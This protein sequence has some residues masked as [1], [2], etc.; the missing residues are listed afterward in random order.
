[1]VPQVGGQ[2]DVDALGPRSVE[3]EVTRA[4]AQ[5]ADSTSRSGSPATRTPWAVCGEH[6]ADLRGELPQRH[7]RCEP[8]HAARAP[9]GFLEGG[10]STT[11][12]AGSS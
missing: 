12:Y 9:V 3:Q 7:R 6:A 11:S 1:M 4:T 2:V 8:A 10:G 5:P